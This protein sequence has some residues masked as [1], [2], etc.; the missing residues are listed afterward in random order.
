MEKEKT[1]V[2]AR[3]QGRINEMARRPDGWVALMLDISGALVEGHKGE[4][5]KPVRVEATV[6]VK[7]L[8]ADQLRFGQTLYVTISTE[9]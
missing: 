3:L 4:E 9:E 6:V 2:R 8:I 5:S 1:A 7:S